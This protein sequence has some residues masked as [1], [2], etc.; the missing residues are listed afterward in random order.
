MQESHFRPKD[1]YTLKVKKWEKTFHENES[2]KK[3][4]AI[5]LISNTIDFVTGDKLTCM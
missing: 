4:R 3:A 5:I 1:I 2:K